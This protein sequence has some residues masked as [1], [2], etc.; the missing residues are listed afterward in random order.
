MGHLG[1]EPSFYEHVDRAKTSD[2]ILKRT[3]HG[4]SEVDIST[5]FFAEFILT[6]RYN[7]AFCMPPYL[8]ESN[9]QYLK[10]HS[11]KIKL[12]HGTITDYISSLKPGT[13]SKFNL[14]DVFE[15]MSQTEFEKVLEC[16]AGVSR[17]G[18]RLAFWTLF[19]NRIIPDNL[20]EKFISCDDLSKELYFKSKTF[21]YGS[22]NV[23]KI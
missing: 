19:I 6:G 1:R 7:N 14:S 2:E 4:L 5:N 17:A 11:S 13:F 10:K 15:Y 20:R 16:L 18:S 12:I 22:F 8:L 21:F 3:K 23:W 9:F